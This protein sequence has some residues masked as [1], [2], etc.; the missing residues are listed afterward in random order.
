MKEFG[1]QQRW[2]QEGEPVCIMC[3]RFGEYVCDATDKDVCSLE[4]KG[5]HLA[6]IGQEK[7][8][9]QWAEY[10]QFYSPVP[11]VCSTIS[12]IFY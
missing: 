4:C 11:E 8:A 12:L 5:I 7:N 10:H 3:G 9:Q 2:P 6:K 1:Y